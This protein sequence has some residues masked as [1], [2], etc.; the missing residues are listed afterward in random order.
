MTA[1]SLAR[2]EMKSGCAELRIQQELKSKL[3]NATEYFVHAG[4][5]VCVLREKDRECHEP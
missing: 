3:L 2:N 1:I 5:M 4:H